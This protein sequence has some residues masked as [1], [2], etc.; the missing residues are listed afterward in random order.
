MPHPEPERK[1]ER[2]VRLTAAR[3]AGGDADQEE[4]LVQEGLIALLEAEGERGDPEERWEALSRAVGSDGARAWR[5]IR[6]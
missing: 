1:P 5:A 2:Q 3:F 4:D 6:R